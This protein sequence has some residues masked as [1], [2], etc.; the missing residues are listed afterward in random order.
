MLSPIQ[1]SV[2]YTYPGLQIVL[3]WSAN[4][5]FPTL[6]RVGKVLNKPVHSEMVEAKV[7]KLKGLWR[8]LHD[9]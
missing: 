5:Y 7:T 8:V 2:K 4:C 1:H 6:L 3:R 9:N